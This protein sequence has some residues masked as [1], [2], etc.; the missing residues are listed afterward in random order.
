MQISCYCAFNYSPGKTPLC[1][2]LISDGVMFGI[3]VPSPVDPTVF[4]VAAVI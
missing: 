4:D 1:L 3:I 2:L